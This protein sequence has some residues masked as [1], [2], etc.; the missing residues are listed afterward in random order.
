MPKPVDWERV[1]A[2]RRAEGFEDE[3]GYSRRARAG[4]CDKCRAPIMAGLDGDLL[5]FTARCDPWP[6][7]A[8]GEL[9]ALLTGRRT[10]RLRWS[11]RYEL[12]PRTVIEIR[13][14]STSDVEVL[15]EHR[16]GQ[17]IPAL[18]REHPNPARRS[19]PSATT[20][21]TEPPY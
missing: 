21:T 16:C 6:V 10:Y 14:A 1:H 17:P 4:R 15:V 8:Q 11:G 19:P 9:L 18:T 20:T 7:D 12:D 2:R 13:G 5:A 3:S